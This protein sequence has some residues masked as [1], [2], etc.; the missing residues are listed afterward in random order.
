MKKI[1]CIWIGWIGVSALA[2]YYLSK[3][4]SIFWSDATQSELIDALRA[5]GC[6]IVIW[7]ESTRLDTSF[8][9]I[10]HTEAIPESQSELRKSRELWLNTQK[11]SEALAEV[12]NEYKLIAVAGTHGKSTTTSM[13]SQLLLHSKED[14]ISVVGTILKEFW[15]KN[16]Y[17]RWDSKNYA[18][19]EAC[20]YKRH[21]LSYNPLV[22]VITNIEFDHADFFSSQKE[23]TETFG[24]FIDRIRPWGFCILWGDVNSTTLVWMRQDIHYIQLKWEYF[25]H[26]G[27][28]Y[29]IPDIEMKIPWE[30]ILYD[31]KLAYIVWHLLWIPDTKI[32]KS[33]AEYSGVWRRMEHIWVT[34]YGNILMSDYGH[35]P[36]EVQVTLEALKKWYPSK[37][38]V[39]VF[40]PHQYS[41]TLELLEWFK[42][43][44]SHAD[45]VIIPNIYASRDSEEDMQ[46]ISAKS[47]SESI[48]HPLVTFGNWFKNTLDI[49]QEYE[50]EH[51]N[52][53]IIV[54]QWAW[55]ID[56]FRYK[57]P[58]KKAL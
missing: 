20:E 5:E 29:K 41:R 46:K 39:V 32:L 33:L 53:S 3:W 15:W 47:L 44:F 16:F 2:R 42:N 4:Y 28:K 8:E 52:S 12:V 31:G 17:K 25:L 18:V 13:I 48:R 36:S 50:K 1:Y 49:L 23:Y 14:F 45:S 51:P 19:I 43:C 57:I 40:Q 58:T 54:L 34:K 10:I 35:H 9:K 27:E 11:Y 24:A 38:L 22:A 30:H 6:D 55:D 37:K 21:F 56:T 7:E 26:N